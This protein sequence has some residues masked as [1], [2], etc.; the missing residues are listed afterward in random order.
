VGCVGGAFAYLVTA[1]SGHPFL[2]PETTIPFW[3]V[4]G[5]LVLPS[6]PPAARSPWRNRGAILLACALLATA[7]MR[8]TGPVRL[9]PGD[10][11]V[12]P[13]QT[14]DSGRPFREAEAAAS[15]F[16]GPTAT[17]VEIPMRLRGDRPGYVAGVSVIV[18]G[19]FGHVGTV[20]SDWTTQLVPLPGADA[21][22]PRQRINLAIRLFGDGAPGTGTR[23]VDVGQIRIVSIQ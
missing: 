20:G 16:V 2:V 21:L 10:Y 15:L 4:L 6:S 8:G 1:L 18:P 23:H 14:D 5:L 9:P 11:G 19:S 17:S 22:E 12:G 13:W 7:P 3:I